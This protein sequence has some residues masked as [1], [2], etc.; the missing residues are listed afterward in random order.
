[1]ARPQHPLQGESYR[2]T[3]PFGALYPWSWR[4]SGIF[5][6]RQLAGQPHLGDDF[7]IK[8]STAIKAPLPMKLTFAGWNTSY[9]NLVKA[10]TPEGRYELY[11]AHLETIGIKT[12]GKVVQKGQVFAWG[13][14]TGNSTADHLHFG[15]YDRLLRR[16]TNPSEWLATYQ[17]EDETDI[18]ASEVQKMFVEIWKRQ[19]V[20][21]DW[22]VFVR[23]LELKEI[24]GRD[25]LRS[26]MDFWA[27]EVWGAD[28]KTFSPEGDEKW[29]RHKNKYV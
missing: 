1:M 5:G 8:K 17:Y 16:W 19:P 9:G 25:N 4:N 24:V 18:P 29:Q 20:D 2:L 7:G 14:S 10:L 15:V 21:R 26:T 6:L 11:F 3:F 13:D 22:K 28:R 12:I 27:T 23:R